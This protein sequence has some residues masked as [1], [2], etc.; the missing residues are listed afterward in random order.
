M[1]FVFSN[2]KFGFGCHVTLFIFV[3]LLKGKGPD[4]ILDVIFYHNFPIE[5]CN[6]VS[7]GALPTLLKNTQILN[8]KSRNGK[9]SALLNFSI[10]KYQPYH[11]GSQSGDSGHHQPWLWWVCVGDG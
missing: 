10:V 6:I 2:D 8:K 3:K 1:L 11:R 5:N 4:P 7:Q 9:H